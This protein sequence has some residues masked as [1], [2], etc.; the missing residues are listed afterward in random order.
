MRLKGSR[1]PLYF[2]ST[3]DFSEKRLPNPDFA[4]GQAIGISR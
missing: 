3:L 1:A 2:C 4:G